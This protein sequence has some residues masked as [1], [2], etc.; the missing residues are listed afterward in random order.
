[1]AEIQRREKA[2]KPGEAYKFIQKRLVVE[3]VNQLKTPDPH[4]WAALDRTL[5]M[6]IAD[7][8]LPFGKDAINEALAMFGLEKKYQA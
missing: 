4:G 8:I 6:A 3:A 2:A 5:R 1:L 7:A